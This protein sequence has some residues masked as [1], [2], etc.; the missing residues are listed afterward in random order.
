M[1]KVTGLKSNVA[2]AAL[3]AATFAYGGFWDVVNKVQRTVETVT[4][5][6]G[7]IINGQPQVVQPQQVQPVQVVQPVQQVPVEQQVQPVAA[8]PAAPAVP[9]VPAVPAS[10]AAAPEVPA[11]PAA[12]A[13]P[14]VPEVPVVDDAVVASFA[15]Q[16]T[17]SA[18]TAV[19]SVGSGVVTF[20]K[21]ATPAQIKEAKDA[22][23]SGG[24]ELSDASLNFEKDVDDATVAA[25]IAAFSEAW[26]VT[27]K[28]AKLTT[29]APFVLLGGVRNIS[30]SHVKC[31]D[32]K[33]LAACSELCAIEL[34]YCDISDLSGLGALQSLMSVNLYGSKMSCSFAPLASC[35]SLETVDFY[36]VKAPKATYD[37]LGSL[38]QVKEFKGGLTK[39][40]SLKWL[41]TCP[42][43]EVLEVFSE[44]IDD[45]SPISSLPNLVRFRGWNMDGGSMATALGDLSFLAPCK[46][47]QKLELPGSVYSNTALIG[48]FAEL[49]ELDLSNAKQP[50]DVS[51]VKSLPNLKC[52]SLNGTEVV[53]G[54]AIP[55]TVKIRSDK[56][57]KGL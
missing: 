5:V 35:S 29:L 23:T 57:T 2:L 36:A 24:R 11:A 45:F 8:T 14:A 22:F 47:L 26:R 18:D 1:S 21:P 34:K 9:A 56:K 44:N 53:N 12:P 33:P 25:G 19:P 31:A 27:V 16:C 39:M 41:L 30:L 43:T 13:A 28:E 37:S 51:F 3:F 52:I 50:V 15:G 54:Q 48:T 4:A 46:K 55:S 7:E 42:Q 20:K 17:T 40:T 32:M 38:T 6:G 10:P 49:E